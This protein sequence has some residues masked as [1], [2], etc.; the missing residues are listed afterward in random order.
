MRRIIF[1]I[2]IAL[3]FCS[4]SLAAERWEDLTPA[5][6]TTTHFY[7]T[8]FINETTGWAAGEN[9][10]ILKTTD[11]GLNWTSQN[12]SLTGYTFTWNAVF[13]LDQNTGYVAGTDGYNGV[14]YKTTDGGNNWSQ[15]YLSTTIS[16]FTDIDFYDSSRGAAC[17]I[18]NPTIKGTAHRYNVAYYHAPSWGEALADSKYQELFGISFAA[19][20]QTCYAVGTYITEGTNK[21]GILLSTDGAMTFDGAINNVSYMSLADVQA[22]SDTYVWTVGISQAALRAQDGINFEIQNNGITKSALNGISLYDN[23]NGWTCGSE[24]SIFRISNAEDTTPLW[25]P[26]TTPTTQNLESIFALSY[27]NAW[28]AGNG[29]I[30]KKVV[31]P[32]VDL[33]VPYSINQGQTKDFIVTGQGFLK[34]ITASFSLQGV[35]ANSFTLVN[36]NE[37]I[38]NIT[39]KLP[40]PQVISETGQCIVTL[41]N[42]DGGQGQGEI[43]VYPE[44]Y[45]TTTTTITTTTTTTTTTTATTST[46]VTTTTTIPSTTTTTT[47]TTTTTT[48]PIIKPIV[49]Y[50]T[51]DHIYAALPGQASA[52]AIFNPYGNKLIINGANYKDGALVSFNPPI[53]F[54][55]AEFMNANQLRVVG[56]ESPIQTGFYDVT[57]T[58]PDQGTD[59]GLDL[60]EVRAQPGKSKIVNAIAFPQPWPWRDTRLTIQWEQF[61]DEDMSWTGFAIDGR[62]VFDSGII[63]AVQGINKLT[64]TVNDFIIHDFGSNGIVLFLNNQDKNK[65]KIMLLN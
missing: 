62:K 4:F 44:G 60:L 54:K 34:G 29:V 46:T 18:P 61:L 14:I 9:G 20:S 57:V 22:L 41:I 36:E 40:S 2:I 1:T 13:F 5:G 27:N 48:I 45:V 24:G 8:F 16:V 37:L 15:E 43:T 23:N 12:I 26:E 31:D 32:I 28:A 17:G 65:L 21:E 52:T 38:I 30:L 64:L 56:V 19:D 6:Y 53:K 7:D 11:R 63:H 35:V 3:L 10:T 59:T 55:Q 51:P 58:N 39:S 42:E 50:V 47:S 25:V 33:I 49:N